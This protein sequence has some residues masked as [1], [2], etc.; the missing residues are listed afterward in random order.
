[1]APILNYGIG[2]SD[3]LCICHGRIQDQGMS[4]LN[5]K[6][7]MMFHAAYA[8]SLQLKKID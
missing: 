4:V 2:A 1:M 3:L 8:R 6:S 7:W 5:F